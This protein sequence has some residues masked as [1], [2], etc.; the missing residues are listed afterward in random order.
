VTGIT[1]HDVILRDSLLVVT[2]ADGYYLYNASDIT[3]P[4]QYGRLP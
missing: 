3:H 2:A 4:V 1:P